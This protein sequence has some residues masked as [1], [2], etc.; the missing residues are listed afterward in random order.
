MGPDAK[1]TAGF[2]GH[3]NLQYGEI[4]AASVLSSIL[5]GSVGALG[6]GDTFVDLGSGTCKIPLM[7]ALWT[8]CG[9]A[10]GVEYARARHDMA[11]AAMVRL[12]A[13]SGAA[14]EGAAKVAGLALPGGPEAPER[15]ARALRALACSGRV[16]PIHANFLQCSALEEATAVFVNNTVFEASLSI[17]MVRMLAGLPRLRKVCS[18]KVRLSRGQRL[19]GGGCMPAGLCQWKE[20]GWGHLLMHQSQAAGTLKAYAYPTSHHTPSLPGSVRPSQR[21]LRPQRGGLRCLCAPPPRS[22]VRHHVGC[23]CIAVGL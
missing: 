18:I 11:L 16:V 10:V 4:A 3:L 7:A 8:G 23:R 12:R 19:H 13:L 5:D 22:R 2:S 14:V 21:A 6:A 9:R 20:E 15:I 1:R 17:A